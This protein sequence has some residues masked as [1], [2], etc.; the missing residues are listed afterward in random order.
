M[1]R[2]KFRKLKQKE[3]YWAIA[4]IVLIF[5]AVAMISG[6]LAG[7]TK[8]DLSPTE[9]SSGQGV[10]SNLLS[11][12]MG[13]SYNNLDCEQLMI[14]VIKDERTKKACE[15]FSEKGCYESERG[16]EFLCERVGVRF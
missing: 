6:N 3:K 8:A 9:A 1:K 16:L 2:V 13:S 10:F 7:N 14:K 5:L 15:L 11:F 12:F 4:G